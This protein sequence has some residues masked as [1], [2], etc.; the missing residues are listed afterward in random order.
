MELSH[1]FL[2]ALTFAVAVALPGP[3][4][5][6]TIG[7][8]LKYGRFGFI[9]APLG[10][11]SATMIHALLVLSGLA[12]F[13]QQHIEVFQAIKWF[14]VLYLVYLAFKAFR[15]QPSKAEALP[16]ALSKRKMYLSALAVSLTN[17]KAML[18]GMALFPLFLQP[19]AAFYPQVFFLTL[20][21]MTISFSIYFGY[22]LLATYFSHRVGRS[23]WVHKLLGTAYLG[24]AVGI[25]RHQS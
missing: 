1:L 4:S 24:A 3:N 9:W 22:G 19:N 18:A 15:H 16:P 25:A 10:F 21:A 13:L 17:P 11:M 12:L 7:Q 14:G 8:A 5:A 2:F 20:T 23:T 6:F